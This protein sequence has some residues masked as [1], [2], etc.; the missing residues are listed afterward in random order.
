MDNRLKNQYDYLFENGERHKM[1]PTD[2]IKYSK[3]KMIKILHGPNI[4]KGR[5]QK[6]FD[7][8]GWHDTLKMSFR[9]PR[10]YRD[11]L[12]A[13]GIEEWGNEMP[14]KYTEANPP[15]WTEETIRMAVSH[16]VEIGSVLA[17]ALKSGELAFPE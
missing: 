8:F 10:H 11:Y 4:E 16:G 9:G 13:N 17:E 15:L 2:A 3:R 7:G 6:G 12:K 14:P 1:T 5:Q